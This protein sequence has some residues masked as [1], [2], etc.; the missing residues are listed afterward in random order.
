MFGMKC[1]LVS[2]GSRVDC[3]HRISA[4]TTALQQMDSVN[5]CTQ[6]MRSVCRCLPRYVRRAVCLSGH[7]NLLQSCIQTNQATDCRGGDGMTQYLGELCACSS[8]YFLFFITLPKRA[9]LHSTR[10]PAP[11]C[12][13]GEDR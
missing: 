8:P 11:P 1:D 4:K 9:G 2:L 12:G 10:L 3:K 7:T 6:P 13:Q 5:P